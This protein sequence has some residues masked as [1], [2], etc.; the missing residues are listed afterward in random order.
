METVNPKNF[1][2][3]D[4]Y[5]VSFIT[6]KNGNMIMID[7]LTPAKP[8]KV[9]I[10]LKEETKNIKSKKEEKLKELSLSEQINFSFI[11]NQKSNKSIISI[12]KNDFNLISN[13]SKNISFSFLKNANNIFKINENITNNTKNIFHNN[14]ASPNSSIDLKASIIQNRKCNYNMN[15]NNVNNNIL[16]DD[17]VNI[18]LSDNIMSP[19]TKNR[20]KS[21]E[22]MPSNVMLKNLNDKNKNNNLQINKI[23]RDTQKYTFDENA[24]KEN[25]NG[26]IFDIDNFYKNKKEI[27]SNNFI[28]NNTNNTN[29]NINNFNYISSKNEN[30]D[31]K[32]SYNKNNPSL[33]IQNNNFYN[34]NNFPKNYINNKNNNNESQII[35]NNSNKENR[36][37]SNQY[38]RINRLRQKR[39]DNNYVKAVVS[40]NIPA[41]EEEV[42]DLEKQFNSLVDRLNGQKSKAKAKEIIK[43]SDR[44]YELYKNSNENIFTS[45]ISPE[46]TKKNYKNKYFFDIDNLSNKIRNKKKYWEIN[47]R[48]SNDISKFSNSKNDTLN[49]RIMSLKERSYTSMNN[50]FINDNIKENYKNKNNFSEIVLPSNFS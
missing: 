31:K 43:R 25:D 50:S 42:I 17:N 2:D 24:N 41:E 48:N 1:I 15:I 44:Y 14:L 40:I 27:I 28:Q 19:I 38:N 26:N 12:K 37:A 32:S 3:I 11:G 5:T 23:I 33:I 36:S 7:E 39:K 22:T 20:K 4:P 35:M 45:L 16:S 29:G 13:I 9:K 8:N 47:T 18:N 49:S 46:K 34:Q 30:I 6:L 21:D 10:I